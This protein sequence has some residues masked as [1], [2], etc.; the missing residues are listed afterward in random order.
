MVLLEI[1]AG[2]F[3]GW[4]IAGA[5]IVLWQALKI[6]GEWLLGLLFAFQPEPY[7]DRRTW[8]QKYWSPLDW[9]QR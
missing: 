1:L 3:I 8:K 6:V 7:E 9:V 4:G 5:V 2:L